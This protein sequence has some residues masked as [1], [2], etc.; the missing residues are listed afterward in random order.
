MDSSGIGLTNEKQ[1]HIRGSRQPVC[2]RNFAVCRVT[3]PAI[4][5]KELR[6]ERGT[7]ESGRHLEAQLRIDDGQRNVKT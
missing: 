7:S 6:Q 2:E 4:R 5:L 1:Q 3:A